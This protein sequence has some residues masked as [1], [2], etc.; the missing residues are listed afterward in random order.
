MSILQST[1]GAKL[2]EQP[3]RRATLLQGYLLGQW[4]HLLCTDPALR[5]L[6]AQLRHSREPSLGINP[7]ET[8]TQRHSWLDPLEVSFK[9][10][11]W[12]TARWPGR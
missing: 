11:L 8:N 6:E 10:E 12:G 1:L 3:R 9:E 4:D 2:V 5:A 7:H